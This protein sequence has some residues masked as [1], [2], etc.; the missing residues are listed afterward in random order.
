MLYT[1]EDLLLSALSKPDLNSVLTGGSLDL[2]SGPAS[3][4]TG[5]NDSQVAV[6]AEQL[7]VLDD[8]E[9]EVSKSVR[10]TALVEVA[11]SAGATTQDYLLVG[12]SAFTIAEVAR[13]PGVPA[14][15]GNDYTLDQDAPGGDWTARFYRQQDAPVL[16]EVHDAPTV[17]HAERHACEIDLTLSTWS[18]DREDTD[19]LLGVAL[20]QMLPG[21]H[22]VQFVESPW[23]TLPTTLPPGAG[24][25][26]YLTDLLG[27]LR[28]IERTDEIAANGQH[29]HRA[30]ALLHVRA[31]LQS[32]VITA[33]PADSGTIDA[34]ELTQ[35]DDGSPTP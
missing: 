25:R 10:L 11:A 3:T 19:A 29:K 14:V 23:G 20:S 24:V 12:S 27:T 34:V 1:L 32:T 28:E 21:L 8:P 18:S 31:T 4:P 7:T 15:R 9:G 17:G 2:L 6:H 33:T 22:G 16:F 35:F 26:M 5:N 30:T 13:P